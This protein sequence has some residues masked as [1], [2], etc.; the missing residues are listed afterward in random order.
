M[1]P[2]DRR[3]KCDIGGCL[4]PYYP[5]TVHEVNDYL[6]RAAGV[7]GILPREHEPLDERLDRIENL[8]YNLRVD[9]DA[10]KSELW[11]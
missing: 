10:L 8:I 1:R 11:H 5:H 9:M 4:T 3:R 2:E 7:N 6:D